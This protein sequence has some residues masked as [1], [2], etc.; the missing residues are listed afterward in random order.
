MESETAGERAA[1]PLAWGV[2]LEMVEAT[3]EMAY[4]R[5]RGQA[6][7]LIV[8]IAWLLNKSTLHC[9]LFNEEG[10]I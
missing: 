1:S 8:Q 9:V 5:R 3:Q 6:Q 7:P 10:A 2:V 4:R